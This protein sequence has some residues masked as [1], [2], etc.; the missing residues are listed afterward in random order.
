M[1][2]FVVAASVLLITTFTVAQSV[3]RPEEAGKKTNPLNC[4]QHHYGQFSDWSEPVNLN[5]AVNSTS[6]EQ[7]PA[8]APNDLSL[9][10]ATN[11]AGGLGQ[12]DIWVSQRSSV[13]SDWGA[14]KSVGA[15]VNSSARDNSPYV[16][17]DGH[18]L[19][20]AS[21]RAGGCGGNDLYVSFRMKT[22]DDFAWAPAK[23]L[24]C[25]LNS[26]ADE[27]APNLVIDD[28]DENSITL[29]FMSSRLGVFNIYTSTLQ[30]DGTFIAPVMVPELNSN[31]QPP[32]GGDGPAWIRNDG[33][34]MILNWRTLGG[35]FDSSDVFVATRDS[36]KDPWSAPVPLSTVVN[37][38]LA[39]ASPSLSCD[40]T[41]LYFSSNRVGG[42]GGNDLWVA[43]RNL[44]VRQHPSDK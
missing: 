23:N 17:P 41:T 40:G 26:A 13:S 19:L 34:E 27:L 8:I 35:I 9:Y 33:R 36:L 10:F 6:N 2:G 22:D 12:Q 25:Q 7:W 28:D 21:N 4:H 15:N 24:G 29:N 42:S 11:R 44:I 37:T 3:E 39:E 18:W 5:A 20:F 16:S 43:T 32:L 1:R 31:L 38:N 14:P 30:P